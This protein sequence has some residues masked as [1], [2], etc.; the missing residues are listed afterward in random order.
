MKKPLK[1]MRG[2][3]DHS[4]IYLIFLSIK[5][6]IKINYK[7]KTNKFN[8]QIFLKKAPAKTNKRKGW[9]YENTEKLLNEVECLLLNLATFRPDLHVVCPFT[10]SDEPYMSRISVIR[11]GCSIV[12]IQ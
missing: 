2:S 10:Y 12:V 11:L 5:F 7:D 9:N 1:L 8:K 4:K 6:N 3:V